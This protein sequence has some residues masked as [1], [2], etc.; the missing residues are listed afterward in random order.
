MPISG[1][2]GDNIQERK[3]ISRWWKGEILFEMFKTS[4]VPERDA[5]T[6]FRVPMFEAYKDAG[7]VMALGKVD[8]DVVKPG[9]ECIVSLTTHRFP[10]SSK[11]RNHFCVY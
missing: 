7:G 8:Q 10:N 4:T 9:A 6:G 3:H 5:K 1:L 11:V 2:T